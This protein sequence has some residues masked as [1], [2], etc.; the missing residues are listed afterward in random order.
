VDSQSVK[1][2]DRARQKGYDAGK[3]ISGVKRHLVV[4]TL[5]LPHALAM[6]TAD[7]ADRDGGLQALC[8][9]ADYLPGLQVILTDGAYTG[10]IFEQGVEALLGASVKVVK[11]S[12]LHK[13][14]VLPK[15]WIVER[16]FAWLEK[17]RRPWKNCERSL[18]GSAQMVIMAFVLLLLR[19]S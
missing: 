4:D 16:S 6:T 3:K 15:R 12:E 14:V 10:P 11:R 8:E 9:H 7:A 1:N 5:G 2:S 13:F 19:R 18:H 17:C